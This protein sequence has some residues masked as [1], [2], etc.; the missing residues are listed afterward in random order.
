[1]RKSFFDEM[2]F[3]ALRT[4]DEEL[5]KKEWLRVY[6]RIGAAAADALREHYAMFDERLYLWLTELY[7]PET[8]GFYYSS[9][10][11]DADGFL[12]DIESTKQVMSFINGT[13]MCRCLG[14]W[15]YVFNTE[16]EQGFISFLKSRQS[17]ENGYFYHPQWEGLDYTPSRLARDL[18]WATQMLDAYYKKYDRIYTE[19]GVPE[20]KKRDLLK[21]YMPDY[22]TPN[23]HMGIYGEPRKGKKDAEIGVT[24]AEKWTPQLRSLD[25]WREYLYEK[26][27]MVRSYHTGSEIGSQATQIRARDNEARALGEPTGYMATTKEFF[28][29]QICP[30]SGVWD[31]DV[32]YYSVNGLMKVSELYNIMGWEIPYAER[33]IESAMTVALFD[34]VD[35]DGKY[36]SGS[37]DVYNPWVVI[38]NIFRNW[39]KYCVNRELAEKNIMHYRKQLWERMPDMIHATSKKTA[40]FAKENGA[41]GYTWG[42][43][44]LR[45]QGMPVSIAGVVEGDV[46]GA[47]IACKGILVNMC[48]GLGIKDIMPS[49]FYSADLRKF[50]NR[51]E[52]RRKF[53]DTS[54]R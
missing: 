1:M 47:N 50:L 20:A 46:N 29:S 49:V 9:S 43:P 37:V 52:E 53:Y 23:G 44:P 40:K 26:E 5:C 38:S 6:E 34:G 11:R 51:I 15:E 45:S 41:Y 54:R 24:G 30:Q 25:S 22:N 3:T 33:G 35:C 8:G 21:K 32:K 12:P 48:D 28:D 13:G 19:A 39:E 18:N 17:S 10:A 14:G 2:S 7:D 4:Q 36:A 31:K 42:V 27:L 16:T